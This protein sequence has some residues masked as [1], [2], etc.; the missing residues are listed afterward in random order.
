[1]EEGK[2]KKFSL[3]KIITLCFFALA[4]V[5]SCVFATKV[6]INYNLS[7][8]LDDSTE[9]KI[10]LKINNDEFGPTGNVQV[11]AENVD[12]GKAEE[13]YYILKDI[14]HVT[15]VNFDKYDTNY[16][17]DGNALYIV[18]IDGDDYSDN[19]KSVVADIKAALSDYGK[20][21]YAGAAVEKQNLQ[22]SITNEMVYILIVSICLVAGIL[23]ITSES[24][25]EPIIIL[26]CCGV[27]VLLNR[28]TNIFFGSISYIT[29]SI[30]AILQLA[31]SID[32]S[33]VL[34]HEYRTKKEIYLD[35]DKAMKESIKS[36]IRPISASSLTTIAG[37]LALLFMSFHIGFDIGIVL[38]KG[39]VISAFTS[40]TLL[41]VMILLCDSLLSKTKKKVLCP[42][43]KPFAD[44]SIKGNKVIFPLALVLVSVCGYLQTKTPYTFTD[45]KAEN[46]EIAEVFGNN[47][48]VVVL[49]KN[50]E[51][52]SEKEDAL[53]SR[54]K[55][56]Q[57]SDGESVLTSYTSYSNTVEVLYDMRKAAQKIETDENEASLLMNMYAL[58]KDPT[59]AKLTFSDFLYYV[60]EL[61]E[62]DAD[63]LEFAD[64]SSKRLVGDII[65]VDGILSSDLSDEE[66]YA[67]V[68]SFD[69]TEI[70]LFS[71][72]Q[73]YGLYFYDEKERSVDFQTMLN[74]MILCASEE[75][76]KSFFDEEKTNQLLSLKEGIAQFLSQMDQELSQEQLEGYMY[77]NY[78]VLLSNEELAMIYA[79][80]YYSLGQEEKETIPFLP[81][82]NF[83]IK[84]NL[85]TDETAMQ[86]ISGFN[87]LYETIN[88]SYDYE[89]FIP[90]L[91][92]VASSLTGSAVSIDISTEAIEQIYIAYFRE[93][94]GEEYEK[95]NGKTLLNYLLS[96][97][98]DNEIVS[99]ELSE[100]TK[101]KAQDMLTIGEY[102]SDETP[103]TYKEMFSRLKSL[104]NEMLSVS[105]SEGISEDKISGP[106]IKY[107]QSLGKD[108]ASIKA[109]DLLDFVKSNMDSNVLLKEKIDD[110]KREKIN[111]AE[112][113]IE[114]ANDLLKGKEYSRMLLSI[115]LPNGGEETTKFVKYLK[116]T[117][118]DIFGE[119]AHVTGEIIS[120][121]DLEKSFAHDNLFITIFTIVS[122]FVIVMLTFRSISLPTI[123]V[124]IIQGA[125]FIT[126]STQLLSSGVFFMS[127][128]VVTCILM[129][130]TIDYGILMSNNYI[131]NRRSMDKKESLQKAVQAAMPT[132][133]TSGLIL[134]ICGF[135]IALISSQSSISTVGLLI[136]I[137]GISSIAMILLVLP[138]T[139][140]LLDGF[141]MKLTMKKKPSN[142]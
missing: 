91:S 12:E 75:N 87:S 55:E 13:I 26:A 10:A 71:I 49:Y 104:Q 11:M 94:T 4:A 34:L 101:N 70:S 66:F 136:G 139:L 38:I 9:T 111:E 99:G 54:I 108:V 117:V 21:D 109:C 128:I 125:V 36:V 115:N 61:F 107:L 81:L 83:L 19:A 43:G 41:P 29:N 79:G 24:W 132:I 112:S 123:L 105:V 90:V 88:S 42:S 85:I 72:K 64:E 44:L 68:S 28:G 121:Y 40:L 93:V 138:S 74:F 142:E 17:K 14:E 33:I 2:K 51:D 48:S 89:S 76:M 114:K 69:D 15:N 63:A 97:S 141:L 120:T 134:V 110:A 67:S 25:V 52:A 133:F 56:Y 129:G 32:Y 86:T 20:I 100:E 18:L 23:L 95:I 6:A 130:A 7:D 122:I 82:M 84:S 62:N 78:G 135:V 59:I 39:I 47:N 80:Y 5:F 22:K 16:Y 35:N 140:Y 113:D 53:A 73:I 127:Y 131:E 92:K 50:V 65:K 8:Y 1:M 103:Y 126:M 137:G 3:K 57:N 98:N 58:Y 30:S 37:L 60:D 102:L 27:A 77:S 118:K 106:Y 96:V 31:L 116:D 45:S 119:E 46:S 124:A